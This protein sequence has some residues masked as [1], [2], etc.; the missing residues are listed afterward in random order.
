MRHKRVLFIALFAAVAAVGIGRDRLLVGDSASAALTTW[1]IGQAGQTTLWRDPGDGSAYLYFSGQ[2][3][4]TSRIVDNTVTMYGSDGV[5][6]VTDYDSPADLWRNIAVQYGV[7]RAQVADGV[8]SQAATSSSVAMPLEVA[9]PVTAPKTYQTH[10][11]DYGSDLAQFGRTAPSPAAVVLGAS[12]LGLTFR[13]A[14]TWSIREGGRDV[15]SVA[16]D[17]VDNATYERTSPQD[18]ISIDSAPRSTGFGVTCEALMAKSAGGQRTDG[19]RMYFR[20]NNGQLLF[21]LDSTTVVS[22]NFT[23]TVSAAQ[24]AAIVDHVGRLG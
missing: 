21:L 17:T 6:K 7:T 19:G 15:P 14:T 16:T 1:T 20:I 18:L 22:V 9:G 5:E 23:S 3:G 10:R 12:A 24:A 4:V 8:A 13:S 2:P 11:V